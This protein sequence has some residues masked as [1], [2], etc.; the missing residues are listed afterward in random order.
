MASPYQ[1]EINVGSFDDRKTVEEL[2]SK[3]D[4]GEK[5]EAWLWVGQNQHDV[6][7]YYWLFSQLKDYQGKIVILFLNNLPFIN[8]KGQIFYPQA[9]HQI[10]P[11]EIIK[12][13]KLARKVSLSEFEIDPDEWNRLVSENAMV[14]TLEGGKK[15]AGQ[16]ESFYDKD[17]LTGLTSEWQKGNR[18]MHNILAKMKIKTGDTFLL[19]RM[20]K[21]AELGRLDIA[22]ETTRG[23]KDFEV[24]LKMT[25]ETPVNTDI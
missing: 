7:G 12:A 24:R 10:L 21:L 9:I 23:W 16:D 17:I 13:K 25:T 19:G 20:K 2:K 1:I 18:A 6:C 4:A 11:K 5:E 15:I 14:R 3:L 22:G 8:E